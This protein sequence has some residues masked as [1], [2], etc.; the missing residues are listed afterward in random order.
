MYV[1]GGAGNN[2]L[3]LGM[4]TAPSFNMNFMARGD[5]NIHNFS[6][7][8]INTSNSGGGSFVTL[9]AQ[10]VYDMTPSSAHTMTI[11][12]QNAAMSSIVT[13]DPSLTLSSG[14]WGVTP[15]LTYTGT[16]GAVLNVQEFTNPDDNIT[17][18]GS[19]TVIDA[20]HTAAPLIEGN[21]GGFPGAF[22]FS[23]NNQSY[24]DTNPLTSGGQNTFGVNTT[25]SV[26]KDN[27]YTGDIMIGGSG[28]NVMQ[29]SNSNF[30][31]VDG[32]AGY[33]RL[34]FAP[35][36]TAINMDFTTLPH[37]SV[38]NI[39]EL[40]LS[41]NTIANSITLDIKNIFDMTSA[42]GNHTL[43]I[44][45]SNQ[46]VGSAVNIK[47]SDGSGGTLAF[48]SAGSTSGENNIGTTV[49]NGNVHY[50]GM[51]NGTTQVTLIINEQSATVSTAGHITINAA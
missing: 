50:T 39:E 9:N 34:S 15:T 18:P 33:N 20:N 13:V 1:D 23:G 35:T 19:I 30:Q 3:E 8:E 24:I 2:T 11:F 28:D 38:R 40:D 6:A 27:N 5:Q 7:I 21:G 36:T 17:N 25:F 10:N 42:A 37:P 26:M 46:S 51:Y 41:N 45:E 29:V 12:A 32:G 44:L 22:S 16:N 14:I 48:D 4:S 49:V 31:L 43:T 47:L